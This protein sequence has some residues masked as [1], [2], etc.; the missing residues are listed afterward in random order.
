[1]MYFDAAF[2]AKCYL[3]EHDAANVRRAAFAADGLASCSLGRVEFWSVLNRDLREGRLSAR[4]AGRIRA[5]LRADEA[6]GVWTWFPVTAPLLD[7]ACVRLESMS[8][9]RAPGAADAIHLTCACLHGFAEIC[10]NDA[11]ML[12]AAPLFG[13]K[14]RD[15]TASLP[16]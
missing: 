7:A 1:M 14:G 10:T 13:L 5:Q 2:I 15:L 4:D 6:S 8:R 12:R 11:Q 16:E 9:G 3:N